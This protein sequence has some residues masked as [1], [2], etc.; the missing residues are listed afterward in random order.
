DAVRRQIGDGTNFVRPSTLELEAAECFLDLIGS[1]EM[2]KFTKDASTANTAALKLARAATGRDMVAICA[3]HPFYS[4]DDWAMVVKPIG[5][6]IPGGVAGLT[7]EFH[8]N[9]I[10]SVERVLE[11]HPGRI[12]CFVLEPERTEPPRGGFLQRLQDLVHADGALLVL[13]E[14]VTGFRW[15]NAGA[16]AVYGIV[17]DLS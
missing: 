14:N 8:Y 3:E 1:A 12:A 16:Q 5:A 13:D 2:V 17:P 9:D 7:V 6:G 15:H 4:Y 10:R 11:E